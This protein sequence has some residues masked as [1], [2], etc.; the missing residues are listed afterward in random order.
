M[1]GRRLCSWSA[2]PVDHFELWPRLIFWRPNPLRLPFPAH[3]L[4]MIF[5]FGIVFRNGLLKPEEN[6][7]H[8]LDMPGHSAVA[9][10]DVYA[11]VPKPSDINVELTVVDLLQ[12]GFE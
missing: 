4:H 8:F 10:I 6:F 3:S 1:G 2:V 11:A 12:F 9:E 7:G 5:R